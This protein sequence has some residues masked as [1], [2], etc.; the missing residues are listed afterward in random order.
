LCDLPTGGC[1]TGERDLIDARVLDE[2][3]PDL[4]VAAHE[5]DHSRWNI[6]SRNS[7]GEQIAIEQRFGR[8]FEDHGATRRQ[9]WGVLGRGERLRIV[10]TH[11]GRHH[12]RG[13]TSHRSGAVEQVQFRTLELAFPEKIRVVA[14]K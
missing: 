11:D 4:V 2:I 1:R 7:F 14:Q 9:R 8:W 13:F 10:P 6:G 3:S 12:T 5:I